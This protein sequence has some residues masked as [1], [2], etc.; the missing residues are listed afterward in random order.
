M[1]LPTRADFFFRRCFDAFRCAAAFLIEQNTWRRCRACR[2]FAYDTPLIIAYADAAAA[3]ADM[4]PRFYAPL[5]FS[6]A[7]PAHAHA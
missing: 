4:L 2:R 7:Q 3:V 5:R 1:M 6:R